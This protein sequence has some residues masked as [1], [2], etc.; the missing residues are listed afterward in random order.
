MT[1]SM[2]FILIV[3]GF[4]TG[5]PEAV[6]AAGPSAQLTAMITTAAAEHGVPEAL[7][8]RIIK[9]ESNYNARAY[10]GGHWGLMQIKYETARSMGYR[11]PAAG[12]LNPET[13]L[14]FGGRYLAGAYLVANRNSERAVRL[15]SSGYYYEAKRKGLLEATRLKAGGKSP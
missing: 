14:R 8:H 4:M 11:G 13:N 12:L 10:H 7:L 1:R 6:K 2:G 9:R 15:Y 3:I 5:L